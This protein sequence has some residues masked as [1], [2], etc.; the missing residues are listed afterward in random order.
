MERETERERERERE[1]HTERDVRRRQSG[2]GGIATGRQ[3]KRGAVATVSEGPG[4]S[5]RRRPGGPATDGLDREGL[6]GR[7]S[8]LP[9]Q[10]A[11]ACM[12]AMAWPGCR[13]GAS[14]QA[15]HTPAA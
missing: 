8:V 5:T 3:G 6:Y 13:G 4:D 11:S 9:Q 12:C 7:A 15:V 2:D 10:R 1:T 14:G